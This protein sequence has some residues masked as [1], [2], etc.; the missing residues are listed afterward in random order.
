MYPLVFQIFIFTLKCFKKFIICP[1]FFEILFYPPDFEISS[2]ALKLL[3]F[4]LLS[5]PYASES[6][7]YALQLLKLVRMPFSSFL[8]FECFSYFIIVT[9]FLFFSFLWFVFFDFFLFLP[10]CFLLCLCLLPAFFSFL[11]S[12][13]SSSPSSV[14]PSLAMA[15]LGGALSLTF[16]LVC[17]CVFVCPSY[18]RLSV[19]CP[20]A[21]QLSI[22]HSRFWTVL[23]QRFG[24]VSAPT[25]P[26]LSFMAVIRPR[27]SNTS[28][29]GRF[30][31]RPTVSL[32]IVPRSSLCCGTISWPL[33]IRSRP[34]VS[35]GRFSGSK[36]LS[37]MLGP[38]LGFSVAAS[39]LCRTL[40]SVVSFWPDFGHL[41]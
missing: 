6:R 4:R 8:F 28:L 33:L 25:Q 41:G 36:P 2:D 16:I 20:V 27:R 21:I 13:S 10:F 19:G 29:S 7:I 38:T 3:K 12:I 35:L 14:S 37:A 9:F 18:L 34:A 31:V 17:I 26:M 15:K 32:P 40:Y 39:R 5:C 23:W 11:S 1:P 24:R 22:C 30:S